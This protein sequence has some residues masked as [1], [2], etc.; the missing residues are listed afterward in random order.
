MYKIVGGDQKE[1]GPV[2]ADQV[3]QWIREGRANEQTLIQAEGSTEWRPLSTF[4]EFA[5]DL[6]AAAAPRSTPTPGG[7]GPFV[8]EGFLERDYDLDIASCL[9]RGWELIKAHFWLVVGT[10]F[11]IMIAAGG[12]QQLVG[13][14]AQPAAMRLGQ[15]IVRPIDIVIV[16]AVSVAYLPLQGIFFGG[17]FAFYLKLIRTGD[18]SVGD[19]FSGFGPSIG[20][21]AL[22]GLLTG[23]L[24]GLGFVLCILPGI[25]L[26]VAWFF[27][28]ALIMDKQMEAWP[29]MELS[30]KIVT[31][32]W[33]IVFGLM[34]VVGLITVAGLVACC[35]GVFVTL[36]IGYAALM[37]AY[38]D[39]FGSRVQAA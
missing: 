7:S 2:T 28:P 3:R 34:L 31:K 5:D 30:R 25:Y 10:T 21:L 23:L 16:A 12:A 6:A 20:P 26:A 29:A 27:V 24:T 39:I 13:L 36:S 8:S 14:L 15:G 32:H 11:L 18:A 1:Y 22:S 38:E 9:S 19:A 4:P 33:W 17:L 35:V 37:Y